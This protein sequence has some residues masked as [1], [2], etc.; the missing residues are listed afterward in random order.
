MNDQQ[1]PSL[2]NINEASR[3][4]GKR[5]E[6]KNASGQNDKEIMGLI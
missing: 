1:K 3:H 4:G 5:M 6:N 2:K